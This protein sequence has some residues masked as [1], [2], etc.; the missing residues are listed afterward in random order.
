[1]LSVFLDLVKRMGIFVIIGQTI[2][3][4]GISKKYERYMKLV[5]SI[6]VAAQIVFA[7]GVYSKQFQKQ[8]FFVNEDEYRKEWEVNMSEVEEKIKNYNRMMTR[9]MEE[10]ILN[11]EEQAVTEE[12]VSQEDRIYVEKIIIP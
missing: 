8:G 1:M 2:Q 9:R 11:C 7:F 5:I 12:N 10:E 4:F 6:M 3:H